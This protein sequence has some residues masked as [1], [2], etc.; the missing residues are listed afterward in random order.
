MTQYII[1]LD[2]IPNQKFQ[3]ELGEKVCLFEFITRGLFLYMNLS[4]DGKEQMNGII[5]LNNVDLIQYKIINI[6]GR[7]Y[8]TDTQ[9]ELDPIY[10]G[11]NDRWLL[12]YE[13]IDDVQ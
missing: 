6:G 2:N 8:F 13:V 3:I 1:P 11:L 12:V 10:W 7:L 4:I 5:C 9:G